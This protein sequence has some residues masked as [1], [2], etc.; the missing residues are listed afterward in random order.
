MELNDYISQMTGA[1]VDAAVLA[2]LSKFV[3]TFNDRKGPFIKPEAN[4][5]EVKQIAVKALDVPEK[6]NEYDFGDNLQKTLEQILNVL[7]DIRD[8]MTCYKE[9]LLFSNPDA[10]T[11]PG[12][13]YL[14][15]PESFLN[16]DTIRFDFVHYGSG[17]W[18]STTGRCISFSI[19]SSQ[20]KKMMDKISAGVS[21]ANTY[22]MMF[23]QYGAYHCYIY[24]K[25]E[26]SFYVN[27]TSNAS[28]TIVREIYGIN[29]NQKVFENS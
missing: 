17:S 1:E 28:Y 3:A 26:T 15:I 8:N 22:S 23:T 24:P 18:L 5:Y 9:T 25:T 21:D 12:G 29:H 4:D 14:N 11:M 19:S 20:L 13:T 27:A 16:F 7:I 2:I 10:T 6:L